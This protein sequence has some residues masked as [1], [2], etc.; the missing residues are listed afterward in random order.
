MRSRRPRYENNWYL[1]VNQDGKRGMIFTY[2]SYKDCRVH[3]VKLR[4]VYMNGQNSY[5]PHS[6]WMEG[7]VEWSK[8]FGS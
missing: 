5:V 3:L 1:G 6:A 4:D 7:G 8:H 2:N